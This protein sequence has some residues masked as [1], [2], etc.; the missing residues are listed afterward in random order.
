MIFVDHSSGVSSETLMSLPSGRLP[1]A[2][3]GSLLHKGNQVASKASLA[4][5]ES[6]WKRGI[7]GDSLE[8]NIDWDWCTVR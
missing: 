5:F 3:P 6:C 4:Q 1:V 7:V 8:S 2:F